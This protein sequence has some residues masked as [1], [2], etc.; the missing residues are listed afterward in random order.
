MLVKSKVN[1]S[2]GKCVPWVEKRPT[3]LGH[4]GSGHGEENTDWVEIDIQGPLVK[5]RRW[6]CIFSVIGISRTL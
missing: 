6:N 3:Q 5:I 1:S 2:W 4:H